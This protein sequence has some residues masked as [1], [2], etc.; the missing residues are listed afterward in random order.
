MK[1]IIRIKQGIISLEL[2]P[3]ITRMV[4]EKAVRKALDQSGKHLSIPV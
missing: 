2:G 1:K 4:G 3:D